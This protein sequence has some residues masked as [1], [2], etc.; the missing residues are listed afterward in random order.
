ME[1]KSLT[2]EQQNAVKRHNSKNSAN[3]PRS[4]HRLRQQLPPQ[5][6]PPPQQQMV[7]YVPPPPNYPRSISQYAN[8]NPYGYQ[9]LANRSVNEFTL[10]PVQE[11]QLFN[12]PLLVR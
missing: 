8:T 10:P 2:K 12:H 3:N 5:H 11:L 7:N 6:L 9:N 1:W 4:D